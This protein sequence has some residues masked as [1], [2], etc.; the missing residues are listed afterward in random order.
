MYAP[1]Q[2]KGTRKLQKPD[3]A[4]W[5][6]I[7][8]L[9][10][11][12]RL[13]QLPKGGSEC[14][15]ETLEKWLVASAKAVRSY[16]YPTISSIDAPQGEED[17]G[18]ECQDTLPQ[19]RQESLMTELIAQQQLVDR[20]SQQ[21][22]ISTVL[23]AAIQELNEE[24]QIIVYLYYSQ[25]LTQQ[26]IAQQLQVKQYTVSRRLA[27]FKDTL[28]LKLTTWC[29]DSL[30]ISLNSSVLNYISTVLEDWLKAYYSPTS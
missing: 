27:K 9:Y 12:T 3:Q 18:G 10:N 1:L 23:V 4:T 20:Q 6:A 28:L 22:Q 8:Q 14:S 26:Q 21:A 25:G 24:E 5:N 11:S 16:F 2:L 19:L 29:Q 7:A 17:A 30:C 13:T 15:A